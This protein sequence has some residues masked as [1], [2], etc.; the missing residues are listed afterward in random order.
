METLDQ[1]T[2]SFKRMDFSFK[3]DGKKVLLRGMSN[4]GSREVI[5]KK[6][7]AI[8]KHNLIIDVASKNMTVNSL[9]HSLDNWW[10]YLLVE[11]SKNTFA[12]QLMDGFIH[13]ERYKVI[14]D[15]IYL[16]DKIYLVPDSKLKKLIMKGF[17][18]PD[19]HLLEDKQIL[20]WEDYNVLVIK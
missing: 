10:A 1:Y 11:Y 18:Q 15:I 20:G 2:Q 5:I 4:K 12:C 14:D 13:D 7:E 3:I 6:M 17:L 8:F 9:P 16:G 19:L